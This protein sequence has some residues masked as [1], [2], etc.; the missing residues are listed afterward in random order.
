M[1]WTLHFDREAVQ[2]IYKIPREIWQ[3]AK[4]VLLSL[5]DEPFPENAQPDEEDPSRLWIALPGDYVVTYEIV[6]EKHIVK[7]IDVE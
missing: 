4:P 1:R 5:Q 2:K 7:I 3:E 6:D